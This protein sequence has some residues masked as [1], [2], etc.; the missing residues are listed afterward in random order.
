M[1]VHLRAIN[2]SR[3]KVNKEK[4]GRQL[5]EAVSTS[6]HL[7]STS[8]VKFSADLTSRRLNKLSVN[9]MPSGLLNLLDKEEILDLLAWLELG[10]SIG[11]ELKAEE[12]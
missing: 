4:F 9:L 11:K 7:A 1:Q 12:K 8:G 5:L 10:A 2:T 3:I 6:C